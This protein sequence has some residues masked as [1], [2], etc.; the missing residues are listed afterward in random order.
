MEVPFQVKP[1]SKVKLTEEEK[2]AKRCEYA[3]NYYRMRVSNEDEDYRA[4]VREWGRAK[5]ERAKARKAEAGIVPNPV[6]R[7]RMQFE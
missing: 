6:G 1:R 3:K 5:Y 7:P 4:K 2:K